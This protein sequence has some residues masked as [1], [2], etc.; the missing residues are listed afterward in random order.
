MNVVPYFCVSMSVG[1]CWGLTMVQ[2]P[3]LLSGADRVV[4]NQ[5]SVMSLR[6]GFKKKKKKIWNFPF[7][8][9]GGG[10]GG[11]ENSFFFFFFFSLEMV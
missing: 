3:A 5:E 11:G 1:M 2:G 4:M 7:L 10:G 6:E 8:D 9:G